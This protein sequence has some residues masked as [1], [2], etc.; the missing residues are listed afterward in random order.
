MLSNAKEVIDA[1]LES[2]SWL[3]KQVINAIVYHVQNLKLSTFRT[4]DMNKIKQVNVYDN[5][6]F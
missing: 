2:T 1:F 3:V 4:I 5:I 6:T